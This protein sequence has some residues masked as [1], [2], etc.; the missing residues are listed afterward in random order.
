MR[1]PQNNHNGKIAVLIDLKN[2]IDLDIADVLAKAKT[3]GTLEEIRAYSDFRQN[4]IGQLG[5]ELLV[6]NIHMVHCPSHWMGKRDDGRPILKPT[7][8]VLMAKEA[9]DLLQTRPGIGTFV[10]VGG[11][12]D[13]IPTCLAIKAAGKRVVILCNKEDSR[14]IKVSGALLKCADQFLEV[15]RRSDGDLLAIPP[16]ASRNGYARQQSPNNL[17]QKPGLAESGAEHHP[18][19]VSQGVPE[20]T[21]NGGDEKDSETLRLIDVLLQETLRAGSQAKTEGE[22]CS[23]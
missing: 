8:D 2:S 4:H 3:L 20:S 17:P 16:H 9:R 18:P 19:E 13:M 10:L 15:Q 21:E 23:Q 6:L 22:P 11:D 1:Q 5:I 14:P 7:D 12:S